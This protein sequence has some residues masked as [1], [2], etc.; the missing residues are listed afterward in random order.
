MKK[1]CKYMKLY[2]RYFKDILKPNEQFHFSNSTYYFLFYTMCYNPN[3]TFCHQILIYIHL[4]FPSKF[5]FSFF[6]ICFQNLDGCESLDF[7]VLRLINLK[8]LS[9]RTAT[10]GS[11]LYCN[12]Q[13]K[14]LIFWELVEW[15]RIFLGSES[16]SERKHMEY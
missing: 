8:S 3:I 6:L 4:Y 9:K 7:S 2:P 1:K 15:Y 11:H 16:I 13:E 12:Q 5:H 10:M 14:K